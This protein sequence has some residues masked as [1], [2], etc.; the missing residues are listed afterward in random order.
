[1]LYLNYIT[2]VLLGNI[3]YLLL[4]VII[5][6]PGENKGKSCGI[7]FHIPD[8]PDGLQLDKKKWLCNKCKKLKMYKNFKILT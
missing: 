2:S 7:L 5:L 8:K 4:N 1:M 6:Y 3:L